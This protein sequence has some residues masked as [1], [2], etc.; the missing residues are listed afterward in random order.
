M[1][2]NNSRSTSMFRKRMTLNQCRSS[3]P[4]SSSIDVKNAIRSHE[5]SIDLLKTYGYYET[6]LKD[7]KKSNSKE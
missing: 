3:N 4:A 5:K 6:F 7:Q 2:S 1:N